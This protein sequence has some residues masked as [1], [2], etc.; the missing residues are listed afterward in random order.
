MQPTEIT[1]FFP[2]D[3][4]SL[5]TE[6]PLLL[7][8]LM[9]Y[10][11]TSAYR[12]ALMQHQHLCLMIVPSVCMFWMQIAG[13]PNIPVAYGEPKSMLDC[14]YQY[15]SKPQGQPSNKGVNTRLLLVIAVGLEECALTAMRSHAAVHADDRTKFPVVIDH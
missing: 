13:C 15:H 14:G 11:G 5:L 7:V 3:F 6:I 2:D 9:V 12:N 4:K 1:I 8:T 10:T